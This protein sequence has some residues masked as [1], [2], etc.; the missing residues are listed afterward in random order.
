MLTFCL[1]ILGAFLTRSGVLSSVHAFSGS[2]IGPVFFILIGLIFVTSLGLLLWRWNSLTA[3][4]ELHSIFSRES[5]FLFNNILFVCLFLICLT[6]VLFPILSEV[7]TGQQVTVGAQW[8]KS[9]TGPLFALLLLLMGIVPL[10]VWG[11]SSAKRLGNELWKPA[12]VSLLIPTGLLLAGIRSWGAVLALW[13]AGLVIL[14]LFYDFWRTVS[15]W[16]SA[17]H[18]PLLASGFRLLLGNHRRYGGL[19][20]HLGVVL[21]AVGIVGIEFFQT[22]TQVTIQQ[23]SSFSFHGDT[24][25]FDGLTTPGTTDD[26]EIT[27][28]VLTVDAGNG[29]TFSLAPCVDNY[30]AQAQSVTVP[31]VWSTPAGD[32]YIVLVDWQSSATTSATF[33]VYYNPLIDWWIGAVVLIL[34]GLFA[35]WPAKSV[36]ERGQPT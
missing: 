15:A 9:T 29:K 3:S 14:V 7:F 30:T 33:R 2:S 13:L 5:L 16:R 36:Q 4:G 27:L 18:E 12:V 10:S 22:Q 21:M 1:V 6:G 17:M 26:H 23:G 25:H 32:L 28:A 31:G 20:V 11:A 8:Y 24:L 35:F 19:L 34:G